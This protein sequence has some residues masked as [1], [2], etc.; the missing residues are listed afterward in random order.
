MC[1]AAVDLSLYASPDND[2]PGHAVTWLCIDVSDAN[3]MPD[4]GVLGAEG[5]V[6]SW[7]CPSSSAP[8]PRAASSPDCIDFFTVRLTQIHRKAFWGLSIWFMKHM[9]VF[10]C[11]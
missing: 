2:S 6:G 8:G 3:M 10:R 1:S 9:K 4:P 5:R 7:E 11:F